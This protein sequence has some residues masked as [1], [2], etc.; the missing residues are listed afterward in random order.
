MRIGRAGTEI[1]ERSVCPNRLLTGLVVIKK[2]TGLEGVRTEHLSQVVGPGE[3]PGL[4]VPAW[5]EGAARKGSVTAVVEHRR[6]VIQ[7]RQREQ[8][9]KRE[10]QGRAV[11]RC[12]RCARNNIYNLSQVVIAEDEFIGHGGRDHID[13]IPRPA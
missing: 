1:D 13:Q 10:A 9:L 8:L 4:A 3:L 6:P 2:Y 11:K 5:M 7:V 12:F